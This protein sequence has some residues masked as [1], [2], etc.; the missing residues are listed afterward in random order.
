MIEIRERRKPWKLKKELSSRETNISLQSSVSGFVDTIGAVEL[1]VESL[2]K[3]R[4][5]YN[6]DPHSL[7]GRVT[8]TYEKEEINSIPPIKDKSGKTIFALRWHQPAGGLK[9]KVGEK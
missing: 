3:V 9:V 4:K 1:Y 5:T 2:D 8:E 6:K 7:T